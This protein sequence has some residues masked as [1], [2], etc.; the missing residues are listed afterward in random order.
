[1]TSQNGTEKEFMSDSEIKD[2]LS[3][4]SKVSELGYVEDPKVEEEVDGWF[5]WYYESSKQID[6]V[7]NT[8][9]KISSKGV[10]F[11]NPQPFQKPYLKRIT[12]EEGQSLLVPVYSASASKEEYPLCEDL[13]EVVKQ[14]LQGISETSINLNGEKIT[15]KWVIRKKVLPIAGGTIYGG[16][17]LLLKA[18]DLGRGDHLLS[19]KAISKNYEVEVK[20]PI[21]VMI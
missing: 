9:E 15:A 4:G 17:W 11:I 12:M 7:D 2:F 3:A 6:N 19:F 20:I 10:Y 13:S 5:Q 8:N 14:D 21:H 16:L 1:M 18:N